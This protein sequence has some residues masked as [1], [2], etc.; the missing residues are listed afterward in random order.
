MITM[1]VILRKIVDRKKITGVVIGFDGAKIQDGK[2][3]KTIGTE[4]AHNLPRNVLLNGRPAWDYINDIECNFHERVKKQ[5][6]LLSAST[7]LVEKE[8]NYVDS[9]WEAH[10][11]L[12]VF[13]EYLY[14]CTKIEIDQDNELEL[15]VDAGG[16]LI[17]GCGETL[18]QTKEALKQKS[19]Y[20]TKQEKFDGILTRYNNVIDTFPYSSIIERYL[21]VHRMPQ[22]K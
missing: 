2:G 14:G 1:G 20:K 10:G 18:N 15:F 16:R 6:Y 7:V 9:Q 4:A 11:L 3:K 19:L 22:Y 8:V 5:I 12:D 13:R 17:A 21:S